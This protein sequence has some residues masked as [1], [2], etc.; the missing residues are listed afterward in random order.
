V[1]GAFPGRRARLGEGKGKKPKIQTVPWKNSKKKKSAKDE[2]NR[3]K[4]R[5]MLERENSVR[6]HLREVWSGP[7][8]RRCDGYRFH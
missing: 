8:V 2:N 7:L 3:K 6:T 4:R 1:A 5:I